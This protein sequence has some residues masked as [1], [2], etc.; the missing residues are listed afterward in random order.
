MCVFVRF[1][2]T[3][4]IAGSVIKLI[5][6][7]GSVK[8]PH[9]IVLDAPFNNVLSAAYHSPQGKVSPSRF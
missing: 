7:T 6:A 2:N 8:S 1:V 5:N 9:G 4:S 3:C